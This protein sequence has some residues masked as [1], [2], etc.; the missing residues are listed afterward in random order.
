MATSRTGWHRRLLARGESVVALSGLML[1]GVLVVVLGASG[2]WSLREHARA[3]DAAA[4]DRVWAIG[5]LLGQRVESMLSREELSP[6][7]TLIAETARKNELARCRVVLPGGRVL[8]DIDVSHI[9]DTGMPSPWPGGTVVQPESTDGNI[10]YFKVLDLTDGRHAGLYV[11]FEPARNAL[12]NGPL[13]LGLGIIGVGGLAIWLVTY[14]HVRNRLRGLGA[15][16]DALSAAAAGEDSWPVLEVSGKFGPEARAWN[17][18]LAERESLRE[19]VLTEKVAEKLAGA[20]GVAGDSDLAGACDALWMGLVIL[21]EKGRVKYI[22]GAGAVLLGIRREDAPGTAIV[23]HV[24][25]EK[26][27]EAIR[28]ASAGQTRQRTT[29]EI[30]RQ[31]PSGRTVLRFTVR[32][33]RKQDA[34]AAIVVVEDVTQQRVADESRNSFVTQVTHELRT[35]LT[36]IGLY[37]ETLTDPDQTDPAVKAKC[38]NVIQQES[39]RLERVVS[40]MLSVAEIE[41]GSLK[42]YQED[43]RLDAIFED[44]RADYKAQAQDKEIALSFELP[45]KLPVIRGDREKIVL[46]LHNLVGNALKYTPQGGQI[47][48]QVDTDGQGVTVAVADN[49]IGIKPEE[50]ELIFEKFYR[51]KDRRIA[52]ITGSGLGLALARQVV[53]LHGGDITVRSAIDKGSTFTMT[54]PMGRAA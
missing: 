40:D 38:I 50:Q 5:D 26:I 7:R 8:A 31:V 42:L 19:K 27:V 36:N 12:L 15:V 41:A 49:G 6:V 43:V 53:R 34:A 51:A 52:G 17:R 10:A 54:L 23:E 1:A 13:A 3:M 35:P 28:V 14:R 47:R 37:L 21:D 45:P 39:K 30:E 44:L 46:A 24:K 4:H 48:V 29:V 9:T 33:M 20:G 32:S 2:W 25:D 22:N 16:S 18:L 11:E